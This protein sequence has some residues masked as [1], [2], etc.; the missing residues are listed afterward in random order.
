MRLEPCSRLSVSGIFVARRS[1][2]GDPAFVSNAT[3]YMS[4]N[5]RISRSRVVS[6]PGIIFFIFFF[7]LVFATPA[8]CGLP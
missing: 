7:A 4:E 2:D 3:S 8:R 1:S 6:F 5:D